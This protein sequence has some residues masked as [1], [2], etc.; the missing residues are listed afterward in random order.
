MSFVRGFLRFA[1]KC[2]W[3]YYGVTELPQMAR[4]LQRR[5]VGVGTLG[6]C[7]GFA[8]AET[9]EN[10]SL[11]AG[12]DIAKNAMAFQR[13]VMLR[14]ITIAVLQI[15]PGHIKLLREPAAAS[16]SAACTNSTAK[17]G[18]AAGPVKSKQTT[19]APPVR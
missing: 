9:F 17:R 2:E 1:E 6:C 11:P 18:S 15:T 10:P 16:H 14:S 12:D 5:A 7:D 4:K 13:A 19:A 8:D 3:V